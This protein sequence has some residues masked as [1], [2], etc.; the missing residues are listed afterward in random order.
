M[1]EIIPPIPTQKLLP[2][3][4][5]DKLI[6]HTNYGNNPIY[7]FTAKEAPM[8][9]KEVGRLR[10]IA[11]RQAGGGTGKDADIDQYDLAET[12]YKQLIVWDKENQEIR[13]GYRYINLRNIKPDHI[14]SLK[15]ATQGL[16]TF[17]DTFMQDYLPYTIELGRSFIQPDYQAKN[18]SR[19]TL[20]ALDNL[21]DGLGALVKN[22]PGVKY[23][24]GKVTMYTHYN[25]YA[26]DLIL[27]FLKKHFPDTKKMVQ[28][29]TPLKYHYPEEE[30]KSLFT[31]DNYK[32]DYKILSKKVRE[33]KE[34]I[35]PLINSYMNLSPSMK[36]FGTALNKNFGGVEETGIMVTINDIY[37]SKKQRHIEF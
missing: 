35:P 26:R 2:E 33:Q 32:D 5:D 30:I 14:E 1:K 20:F 28:P 24:F 18:A 6:R 34:L 7:I 29:V 9:M 36:C 23:F 10:E 13:G 19:K 21:W 12:P 25:R 8:L 16:F 4:T 11:F 37:E 3:L 31:Q 22:N 27:Y 15:L 17:S